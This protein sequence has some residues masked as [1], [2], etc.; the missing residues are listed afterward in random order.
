M[1]RPIGDSADGA[2]DNSSEE[3]SSQLAQLDARELSQIERALTRLE[4]G[5]YGM[6][7]GDSPNCQR[8]IPLARLNALPD[9]TLCIHCQRERDQHPGGVEGRGTGSWGRI[10]DL[11]DPFQDRQINL[12]ELEHS[13]SSA[14]K[15]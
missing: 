9:S 8:R 4:Q 14:W 11:K 15:R 13:M 7:E 12:S 5:T 10:V 1:V 3:M 2:F 6:C